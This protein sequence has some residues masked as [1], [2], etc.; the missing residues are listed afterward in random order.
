MNS[1]L[2]FSPARWTRTPDLLI[3]DFWVS[4]NDCSLDSDHHKTD[5]DSTADS[6]T[7]VFWKLFCYCLATLDLI[8]AN[9]GVGS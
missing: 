7:A 8:N 9:T 6:L 4:I 2:T 3:F 5:E 1:T